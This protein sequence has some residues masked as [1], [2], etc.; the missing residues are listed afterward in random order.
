[1]HLIAFLKEIFCHFLSPLFLY[2]FSLLSAGRQ[3]HWLRLL[4]C[5]SCSAH[6][7]VIEF[8][9][10][11]TRLVR[12]ILV[13]AYWQAWMHTEIFKKNMFIAPDPAFTSCL[14]SRLYTYTWIQ[15][16]GRRDKKRQSVLG[17]LCVCACVGWGCAFR[18]LR[19]GGEKSYRQK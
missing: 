19:Y 8:S 9:D 14:W 11:Q 5:L 6:R 7:T 3:G 13:A 12:N 4:Q 15:I 2:P 10:R 18:R 17:D 1:M 16:H